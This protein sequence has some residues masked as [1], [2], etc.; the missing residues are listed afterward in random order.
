MFAVNRFFAK[1][2]LFLQNTYCLQHFF[3]HKSC[4]AP[5]ARER[6]YCF[7]FFAN[8][9]NNLRSSES[10]V[11]AS[12]CLRLALKSSYT[13]RTMDLASSFVMLPLPCRMS[14]LDIR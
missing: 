9:S 10:A 8:S 2:Q 13:C 3:L 12:S 11:W 4:G 14:L 1:V 6:H 7:I 5:A